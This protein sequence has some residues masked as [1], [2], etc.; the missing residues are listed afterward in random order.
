LNTEM[1]ESI[2]NIS[3]FLQI[4]IIVFL[5]TLYGWTIPDTVTL[6]DSGIF[7][8]TSYFFGIP[9]PTGYPL[10]TL[11]AKS[12]SLIPFGTVALRIH[13]LSAILAILSCLLVYRMIHK[14]TGDLWA[15]FFGSLLLGVSSSFWFQATVAEVYM[16][17]AFLSLLAFDTALALRKRYKKT[18]LM[19]LAFFMGLGCSNHLALFILVSPGLAVLLWSKPKKVAKDLGWF[20]LFFLMGL[21]PYLHLLTAHTHSE[22]LFLYPIEEWT[23]F[24]NYLTRQNYA[25]T[26][27]VKTWSLT[28]SLRFILF[29]VKSLVFEFSPIAFPLVII[30]LVSLGSSNDKLLA[31]G[32]ILGLFPSFVFLLFLWRVEFT[33]L[34]RELYLFYQ[35][36]P[37]SLCAVLIG[38]ALSY[39]KETLSQWSGKAQLFS[40]LAGM[41]CCTIALV[42]T[43]PEN[44]KKPRSF[45]ADYAYFLL[46]FVPENSVL[47][48]HNDFDTGPISYL[49]FVEQ[50]RP[51]LLVTSQLGVLTPVK[52]FTSKVHPS[53]ETRRIP[54]LNFITRQMESGKRVFTTAKF[55]YFKEPISPFPLEYREFYPYYEILK[56]PAPAVHL[57]KAVDRAKTILD[58]Y[59]LGQYSSRWIYHQ[60]GMVARLS[61]GLLEAGMWHPV[62]EKHLESRLIYAQVLNVHQK[63]YEQADQ[64]FLESLDQLE[65]MY[66]SRQVDIHRQFLVNRFN[67]LNS[68]TYQKR[69]AARSNP[70]TL[71][72]DTVDRVFPAVRKYPF[73]DNQL[74]LNFIQI[75]KQVP[76][77]YDSD[78][79]QKHFSH[80][81]QFSKYFP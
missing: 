57:P 20:C 69:N 75:A 73:C 74:A 56:K 24:Y 16:L 3:R 26:L 38:Y 53:E 22:F 32:I 41:L 42:F 48:V 10:Y 18:T 72:Q 70:K 17:H 1:E 51:D 23:D 12:F 55:R 13:W 45:A 40:P 39:L 27:E 67:W 30:G 37:L 7:L 47:L 52:P 33:L 62:F 25:G 79:F 14:L 50:V 31:M 63:K 6:E 8:T 64:I 43:F 46:E 76:I 49:H 28:H 60:N 54:L 66:I 77:H 2:Q 35:L 34:T 4:G 61:Q 59:H 29:F 58:R 9:Q 5:S 15:S 44:A 11:L 81:E 21:L 65:D 80:C 36:V 71:I 19:R 68:G 78:Y